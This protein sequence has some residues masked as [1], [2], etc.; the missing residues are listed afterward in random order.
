M[1]RT[2]MSRFPL[3]FLALIFGGCEDY[4]DY[5]ESLETAEGGV[6][7][8][9]ETGLEW[10]QEPPA[11]FVSWAAAMAYCDSVVLDGHD[12]WHLPTISELRT[13]IT[14]CEA[15]ALEGTC[16]V[17]DE[18][19]G[20]NCSSDACYSCEYGDGPIESCFSRGELSKRCDHYWSATPVKEY[21]TRAWAV[22]FSSGFVYKPRAVYSFHARCVR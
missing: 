17:S 14:G 12:D 9:T 22:G 7:T 4:A 10:Q 5:T 16:N 2:R 15:T 8:D 3:A 1:K 13:L 18:C 11:K 20:D 21:D 6:W 19:S